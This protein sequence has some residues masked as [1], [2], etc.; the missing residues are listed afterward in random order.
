MTGGMGPQAKSTW[1][2]QKLGEGGG[3]LPWSLGGSG[4]SRAVRERVCC[5]HLVCGP[6]YTAPGNEGGL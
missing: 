6:R 5:L 2:H 1:G 3:T 4:A